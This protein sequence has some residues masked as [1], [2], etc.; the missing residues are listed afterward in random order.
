MDLA[1]LENS[2]NYTHDKNEKL[3][4]ACDGFESFFLSKVFDVMQETVSS[5][6]GGLIKKNQGEQIFTQMLHG[7]IAAD[8]TK[9]GS[10]GL[11]KMM[12]DNMSKYVS[13]NEGNNFPR[14]EKTATSTDDFLRLRQQ[15]NGTD[16]AS[17]ITGI[18]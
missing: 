5:L 4:K 7:Q 13:E 8:F 16:V 6:D 14:G 2:L 1:V 10:V 12:Y 17:D 3:K 11:S 15:I 18:N 9:T